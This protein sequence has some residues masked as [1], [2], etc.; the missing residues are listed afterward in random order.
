MAT[1]QS[2]FELRADSGQYTAEVG[3][4]TKS[5]KNLSASQKS[6]A[7]QADKSSKRMAALSASFGR[8]R[9]TANQFAKA[10][11]IAGAAML[12]GIVKN[13]LASAD[14]LA[15]TADKI[16]VTTEMLAGLRH[17]AELSG[18]SSQALDKGLEKVSIRLAEAE[19][20]LTS[21][22]AAFEAL[23]LSTEK[24][25]N[26]SPDQ[27]MY[28]IADALVR[29]ENSA[30]K[31]KLAYDLF[32]KSGTGLINTLA[33]G[34][35]GLQA[36]QRDAELAGV[37][38]S[39]IDARKL[40]MVND[41][42]FRTKQQFEG[43]SQQLAVKFAP[44]LEGITERLFNVGA[45]AGGMAQVATNAFDSI[46][47]AVGVLANGIH[48]LEI[49]WEGMKIAFQLAAKFITDGLAFVVRQAA[50]AWNQ[51]PWTDEWKV[52][53][54][55]GGFLAT[56]D[57][58]IEE[59]Q[60]RMKALLS[61]KLPSERI[62]VFVAESTAAFEAQAIA[63]GD[64]QLDI[65]GAI[66]TTEDVT[67]GLTTTT[68]KSAKVIESA[69][70]KAITG[71]V[72]RIDGAFASAWKGAF[73][74]FG[75][76][77]EGIKG[78]FENLLAEM[79]HMAA[80]R[81]IVMS[82]A[83]AFGMGGASG[84]AAG[85]GGI[86]SVISTAGGVSNF[87]SGGAASLYGS[88][89]S[90]LVAGYARMGAGLDAIGL[91]GARDAAYNTASGYA[92]GTAAANIGNIGLNIGAGFAGSYL[93]GEVFGETTGAGGAVGGAIGSIYGP[94][95]TAV[96]SFIGTGIEKGLG[97]VFGF[98]GG[99]N[100]AA[101]A[102]FGE[103]GFTAQGL[104]KNF[105]E[106]NLEAVEGLAA[107]VAV[108]AEAIGG[109][110][111]SGRLKV[112]NKSG[113]KF[114]SQKFEGGEEFLSFAFKE[115]IKQSTELSDVVRELALSFEGAAAQ[116][117][118]YV[119]NL[120]Q[121]EAMGAL[122]S[123]NDAI[124]SFNAETPTMAGAMDTLN[125]NVFDAI[126]AF[127]GTAES[128]STLAGALQTQKQAA[129]EFATAILAIG[130]AIE[131]NAASSAERIREAVLTPDELR[132]KQIA[133]RDE[134]REGL[135]SLVD[136]AAIEE[137]S[138]R[139]LALNEQIFGSLAEPTAEIAEAFARIAENTALRADKVLDS[140][141]ADG[142]ETEN[143]IGTAITDM[144]QTTAQTQLDAANIYLDATQNF[145]GTVQDLINNGIR[146]SIDPNTGAAELVQ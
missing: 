134:L 9:D 133:E 120:N 53:E 89:Q 100:N 124:R 26:L 58:E 34:S 14:Q 54:L 29:V 123:I 136:P 117:A 107:P 62:E 116:T 146:I 31:T 67:K 57:G 5:T 41:S 38:L 10:A 18:T 23:G 114:N 66:I 16:G 129:Y 98:G 97:N 102:N 19:A 2:R 113:I 88:A 24:M 96:G 30:Q 78:S 101:E 32:G 60:A 55:F 64:S 108:L 68:V 128:S 103:G 13:G 36:M 43:F 79:A 56:M 51:L 91:T 126:E 125:Q 72:E 70:D 42:A 4:A 145:S 106:R 28:E 39:R 135:G 59:S 92:N 15:K 63:I 35:E 8:G 138:G 25:I 3:K 17:A 44:V 45:E 75:D 122:N 87:I 12:A 49:G 82:I 74:S 83:G 6:A 104:G 11:T 76:F 111:F 142:R 37:A 61:E 118:E 127:D 81:P 85:T 132:R 47:T 77:A 137:A 48:G 140:L 20:G 27:A 50:W 33:G 86:G 40:E 95:G 22:K 21:S 99:G 131:Q 65:Q 139:I 141:L 52:D 110:S 144:L 121:I 46:M 94:L 7:A 109:S 90:G 69:W 112:G 115:V 73:D 105:S 1:G 93:G 119:V 80:T 71:T 143:A 84:A 130:Q